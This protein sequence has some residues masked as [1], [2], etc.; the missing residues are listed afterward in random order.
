MWRRWPASARV[1]GHDRGC[2]DEDSSPVATQPSVE[3]DN[4]GQI[5]PHSLYLDL[6]TVQRI[7]NGREIPHGIWKSTGLLMQAVP[8]HTFSSGLNDAHVP[9]STNP[10]I[11]V[12]ESHSESTATFLKNLIIPHFQ[13]TFGNLLR[14]QIAF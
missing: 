9:A 11:F 14:G 8:T 5:H 10:E 1:C 6:G 2:S 3:D 7:R 12:L 4:E 13:Q